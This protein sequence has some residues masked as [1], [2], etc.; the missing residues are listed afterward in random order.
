MKYQTII[1][2]K[3]NRVG[4]ITL[5][6]PE[7]RNALS[8]QL[9]S[10]LLDA[11]LEMENDPDVGTIVLTGA[12]SSFCSG[13]D[14]SE[15]VDKSLMDYRRIFGESMHI[16]ETIVSMGKPV[17]AAVRGYATAM[18]CALAAGCDLV[19]ASDDAMFQ[20]PGINVGASCASP[21]AV[22]SQS[23]G[24]KKCLE[25]M[26]TGDL[27]SAN[28]M[29]RAGL[30]N[31]VVPKEELENAAMELAEKIANKPSP[32]AQFNKKIFYTMLGMER[33]KSYE[34]TT[35]MISIIFASMMGR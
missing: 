17:I 5:N 10:E 11:L 7:T 31:R 9:E 29:E 8:A 21:A 1:V 4:K 35:E 28:E 22:V 23:I 20:L 12:G 6:R 30:V 26:L 27:F 24:V 15:L 13:H 3:K 34:Y 18:G 2:E 25:L 14:L 19:V 32:G 33:H 16:L